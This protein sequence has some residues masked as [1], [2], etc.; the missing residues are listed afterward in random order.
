MT[1]PPKGA[2][3]ASLLPTAMNPA[4]RKRAPKPNPRT[5]SAA[6]MSAGAVPVAQARQA[7]SENPKKVNLVLPPLPDEISPASLAEG[8]A[9]EGREGDADFFEVDLRPEDKELLAS[10]EDLLQNRDRAPARKQAMKAELGQCPPRPPRDEA[11]EQ[12]VKAS[13]GLSRWALTEE[14]ERER[15]R[16]MALEERERERAEQEVEAQQ[17]RKLTRANRNCVSAQS[18]DSVSVDSLDAD[19]ESAGAVEPGQDAISSA[20]VTAEEAVGDAKQAT[21]V[22]DMKLHILHLRDQHMREL[23]RVGDRYDSQL[24]EY[25]DSVEEKINKAEQALSSRLAFL[26]KALGVSEAEVKT[27][28]EEVAMLEREKDRQ[29]E[30]AAA[31]QA[32]LEEEQRAHRASLQALRECES[33][34]RNLHQKQHRD[35][36]ASGGGLV[37]EAVDVSEMKTLNAELAAD[38]Q[39]LRQQHAVVEQDRGRLREQADVLAQQMRH[40]EARASE[41]EAE[42]EDRIAHAVSRASVVESEAQ[43]VRLE[44][45]TARD[46]RE[47]HWEGVLEAREQAWAAAG[48]ERLKRAEE[49]VQQLHLENVVRI[50]EL[51][52]EREQLIKAQLEQA[53]N[54]DDLQNDCEALRVQ[55]EGLK[56]QLGTLQQ[57]ATDKVADKT[58]GSVAVTTPVLASTEKLAR[59]SK[60]SGR[61]PHKPPYASPPQHL[62]AQFRSPTTSQR[63][64]DNRAILRSGQTRQ[65][66]ASPL[67]PQGASPAHG[68]SD[69]MSAVPSISVTIPSPARAPDADIRSPLA[70]SQDTEAE[71]SRKE[72]HPR[73]SAVP[74]HAF[75][76]ELAHAVQGSRRDMPNYIDA[77][78]GAE[79]IAMELIQQARDMGDGNAK[80]ES[81]LEENIWT[82]L[83]EGGRE[84]GTMNIFE[85]PGQGVMVDRLSG[86]RAADESAGLHP[87]VK[88]AR[89]SEL[90]RTG[91]SDRE[92]GALREEHENTMQAADTRSGDLGRSFEHDGTIGDV[93]SETAG[94]GATLVHDDVTVNTDPSPCTVTRISWRGLHVD[95]PLPSVRSDV[96]RQMQEE[97]EAQRAY[98][99]LAPLYFSTAPDGVSLRQML[100]DVYDAWEDLC[101]AFRHRL[102]AA[103][104]MYLCVHRERERET[105]RERE[106]ERETIP[107]KRKTPS[108]GHCKFVML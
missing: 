91:L 102:H 65:P 52:Q 15:I 70:T 105:D 5:E 47:L 83:E 94:G 45:E 44:A 7:V 87:D 20:A 1:K 14:R 78:R 71:S 35:P 23:K 101:V 13:E 30:G 60:R 64:Q 27:L 58:N 96:H 11:R 92:R 9:Q 29:H 21:T 8:E 108:R 51:E 39:Q 26:T 24:K 95:D 41:R 28:R 74:R 2:R 34:V 68:T 10:I 85:S 55:V 99:A 31:A 103:L 25:H 97:T 57:D 38:L 73:S 33:V 88:A 50:R 76:P 72:E 89:L 82:I 79:E 18:S 3:Q 37:A 54:R 59:V 49:K 32:A 46:K 40:V 6:P 75:T 100:P 36:V 43:R 17:S 61:S 63:G 98:E 48:E 62:E 84:E 80:V 42:L 69:S 86:E 19:R 12:R 90:R 77:R 66:P 22:Q 106:R 67:T 56:Q 93:G 53:R 16:M 4:V 81:K 107:D 104:V